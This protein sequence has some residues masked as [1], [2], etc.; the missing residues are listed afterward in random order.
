MSAASSAPRLRPLWSCPACRRAF[1]NRNQS[2]AC[3][4][5]DLEHHFRGRA[6]E[7]RA[8]YEAFLAALRR[9]GAVRVLPEKTRIA[10]QTRMS[11]A[12]LTPRRHWLTGHLVLAERS[13]SGK[14]HKIETIS[15]HNH[16]H[17]FR[18]DSA[19][20]LDGEFRALL[21]AAYAVGNQE[22]MRGPARRQP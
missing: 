6:R 1:A 10:F 18:L 4:R 12:Q 21:R 5:W 16:V 22:H 19:D 2:H 13:A 3:A 8:L 20:F 14:F 11:F 9:C 15:A 7:V 17:H